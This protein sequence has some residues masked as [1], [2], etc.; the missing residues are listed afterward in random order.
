MC[1]CVSS[2]RLPPCMMMMGLTSLRK[3]SFVRA[4][5]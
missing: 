2:L 1:A 5:V 3:F 4:D